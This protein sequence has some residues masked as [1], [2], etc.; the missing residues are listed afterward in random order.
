[1]EALGGIITCR[2]NIFPTTRW[3]VAA[4][5]ARHININPLG[6]RRSLCNENTGWSSRGEKEVWHLYEVRSATLYRSANKENIPPFK[7]MWTPRV[8][9]KTKKQKGKKLTK[10]KKTTT[11]KITFFLL[12]C[13]NAWGVLR[14][15]REM[16]QPGNEHYATHKKFRKSCFAT[17]LVIS[18]EITAICH[19]MMI[20]IQ[21]N[22]PPPTLLP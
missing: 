13:F 18:S 21:K 4:I 9:I 16:W 14:V 3:Q 19:Q 22:S 1:M 15:I 20:F 2:T 11:I 6:P 8:K 12:C 7:R 17:R 10:T 5:P